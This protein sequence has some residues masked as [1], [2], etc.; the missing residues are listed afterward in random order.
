MRKRTI[1]VIRSG[2]ILL[3]AVIGHGIKEWW[4]LAL[5]L[6]LLVI[7]QHILEDFN[8]RQT[9]ALESRREFAGNVEP[10]A[11]SSVVQVSNWRT[12]DQLKLDETRKKLL[13]SLSSNRDVA[14]KFR[15]SLSAFSVPE[16]RSPEQFQKEVEDWFEGAVNC[17]A[18]RLSGYVVH[19]APGG[20]R[21]RIRNSNGTAAGLIRL[22]V[23][24]P[25]DLL[26]WTKS[27][28]T[29]SMRAGLRS[30][31]PYNRG[32]LAT[33]FRHLENVGLDQYS[34]VLANTPRMT[35]KELDGVR[36]L[37]QE[38][39]NVHAGESRESARIFLGSDS[40]ENPI[41]LR[42]RLTSDALDGIQSGTLKV[43]VSPSVARID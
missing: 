25:P 43:P 10:E 1:Q 17:T 42:W 34:P 18:E 21:F 38:F 37:E 40:P 33:A 28:R 41:I 4:L 12:E 14:A 15:N 24:I 7:F 9:A 20:V 8:D 30:P 31:S 22:S 5:L 2:V 36:T 13:Q 23:E 32:T 26:V 3:T 29:E 35:L 39:H 27:V 19:S 16:S 11:S 6:T